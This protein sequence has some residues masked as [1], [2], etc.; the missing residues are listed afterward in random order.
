PVIW[1]WVR[2]NMLRAERC[3]CGDIDQG[4]GIALLRHRARR[5][6]AFV[7]RLKHLLDLSLHQQF[8]VEGDLAAAAS[9]DTEET[10]DLG[11]AV[12]YRMPRDRRLPESELLHKRSLNLD[13]A[14]AAR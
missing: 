13:A 8:H 3:G 14:L 11:N 10:P 1:V 12:A 4:N 6:A 2:G 5:A 9:D 7:K